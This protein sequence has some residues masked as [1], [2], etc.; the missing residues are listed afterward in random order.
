MTAPSQ[1]ALT[2][3]LRLRHRERAALDRHRFVRSMGGLCGA[4]SGNPAPCSTAQCRV[5][6]S[7]LMSHG[8]VK[9]D[10]CM[11]RVEAELFT[12]GGNDAVVRLPGR[13]FPGVLIQG[14][15]LASLRSEVAEVVEAFDQGDVEEGREA[16]ILLLA[17]LDALLM[18]YSAALGSAR[19]PPAVLTPRRGVRSR[20]AA[21]RRGGRHA[22]RQSGD[23]VPGASR[24]PC[25]QCVSRSPAL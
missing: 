21:T 3:G 23:R 12:D 17:G 11:E 7:P 5:R 25:G 24:N 1:R 16:A 15:S 22:A 4:P 2:D 19:D 14:D 13:R 9:L 20:H 8:D 18:R 6:P 10:G